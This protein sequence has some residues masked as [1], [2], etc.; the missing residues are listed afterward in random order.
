[1]KAFVI[2]GVFSVTLLTLA[3]PVVSSP[4]DYP[5]AL[6]KTDLAAEKQAFLKN[7]VSSEGGEDSEYKEVYS[8]FQNLVKKIGA[9]PSRWEV[10]ESFSTEV[11]TSFIADE[12][13]QHVMIGKFCDLC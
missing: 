4:V 3:T 11:S 12:T 5:V 9:E 6:V 8:S 1:M 2:N 10:L 13:E 7:A